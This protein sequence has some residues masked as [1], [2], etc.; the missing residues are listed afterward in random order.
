MDFKQMDINKHENHYALVLQDYLTKWPE[1][2][3]VT[4]R[5]AKTVAICL[6]KNMEYLSRLFMI[7]L[8]SS[9]LT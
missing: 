9:F 8:L 7:E 2:Y 5:S 6:F 1:V 3:A 4:G